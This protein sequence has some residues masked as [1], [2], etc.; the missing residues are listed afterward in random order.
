M[1]Q[2]QDQKRFAMLKVAANSGQ[3]SPALANNN[4]LQ[5]TPQ[6]AAP[7]LQFVAQKLLLIFPLMV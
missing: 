6:S 5:L 2:T 7:S 3:P 4:A 1:S